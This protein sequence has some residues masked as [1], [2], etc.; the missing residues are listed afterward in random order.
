MFLSLLIA[1]TRTDFQPCSKSNRHQV[2]AAV[3][4]CLSV[5][6]APVLSPC[7][8]YKVLVELPVQQTLFRVLP[9]Q[10]RSGKEISVCVV[11]FTQGVNEQQSLADAW[12]AI[13]EISDSSNNVV[14]SHCRF[15][16]S[17]LQDQINMRS[18]HQLTSYC[19]RYKEHL[20]SASE[21]SSCH[22][23]C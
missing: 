7:C 17:T 19:T 14:S 5:S 11:L 2:L 6:V 16:D 3:V 13:A 4:E 12:V 9:S 21:S 22:G 10:L 23:Y 1:N 18:L 15:G 20:G 8:R